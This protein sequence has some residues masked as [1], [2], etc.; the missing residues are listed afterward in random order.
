[1]KLTKQTLLVALLALMLGACGTPATT[2][3]YTLANPV[4]AP[5]I[6]LST[7]NSIAIEVLPINVP[8]R[9]KRPQLVV[10]MQGSTQLKILE[11]D[12]WSSSFNDELRDAMASGIASQLGATDVSRGG[13]VANQSVYRIAVAL[14]QFDALPGDKVQAN[15]G[16]TV[17]R[18]AN[19]TGPGIEGSLACQASTSQAVGNSMDDIAKGVR[20]AVEEIVQAISA[21]IRSLSNGEVGACL[22]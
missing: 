20:A 7:A 4:K 5:V 8:E 1:M 2:R 21:N 6:A 22:N 10:S 11:Q 12:R 14:R 9:L 16:W 15:F 19:S 18:L 3:F 17:T 13:R